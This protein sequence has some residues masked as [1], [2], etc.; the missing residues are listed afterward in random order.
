MDRTSV[1]NK[2]LVEDGDIVHGLVHPAT[3]EEA[4]SEMERLGITGKLIS[5]V[6]FEKTDKHKAL[7]LREKRSLVKMAI[8][9]HANTLLGG[10][11]SLARKLTELGISVPSNSVVTYAGE[12][13]DWCDTATK[14][15][16]DAYDSTAGWP[17]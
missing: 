6:D 16:L 4:E 11:Y 3:R 9:Q 14:E 17:I 12:Q 5:R 1:E 15:Q 8:G 7:L 2:W 10:D 13:M